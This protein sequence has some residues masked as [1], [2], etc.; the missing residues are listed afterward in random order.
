VIR[1]SG[2][3]GAW[4][5]TSQLTIRYV[6]SVPMATRR[7]IMRK[8]ENMIIAI[9]FDG[10]IVEHA[11][12]KI[13]KLFPGAR[14]KIKELDRASAFIIIWTC[15]YTE[16]NLNEMRE[17]LYKNDIPYNAINT[18]APGLSF[19]PSPKIYADVYIDDRSWP[20]FMGW[21]EFDIKKLYGTIKGI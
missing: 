13:G 6:Q 9:D 16:K 3:A 12:P 15:R 1:L 18:N 8:R 11:Y 14:D 5:T 19:N 17:F 10:T 7:K 21:N 2:S 4:T 20:P